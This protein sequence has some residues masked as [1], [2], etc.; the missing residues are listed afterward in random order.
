MVSLKQR[1]ELAALAQAD[2]HLKNL[3]LLLNG[4]RIPVANLK[5]SGVRE[6]LVVA[7]S[8]NN[9][10]QFKERAGA[11]GQRKIS[12]ESDWCR[13]DYLLF[14]LLLGNQKFGRPLNFLAALIDARRQNPN[15]MPQKINEVFAALERE[16]FSIDGEYGFLKIPYL[17]LTGKLRMGPSE[18][19]KAIQAMST[20]GLLD[21]MS[22]FL[23]LLTQKAYDLV[24]IERQ[25]LA[26]DTAAQLIEGIEAHAKDFSL[27]QWWRVITALPCRVI[28]GLIAAILSVGLIPILFGVGKGLVEKN[29]SE[30]PRVHP[31][32]IAIATYREPPPDLPPEV[33]ALEK[34]MAQPDVAGKKPLLVELE[35]APFSAPTSA[36][37]VEVS[38]PERAIKG[39]VAFTEAATDGTRPYTVVPLEHDTGRVRAILPEEPAGQKLCF[40]LVF[41][42]V[43]AP[44]TAE[45]V[46][47][48]VVVRPLQ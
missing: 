6:D 47:K 24:L 35:S 11:I 15:P 31:A 38:H 28:I 3:E 48:R 7:I 9:S 22:P 41:D 25:P 1:Q 4:E 44:E 36:F 34:V 42:A 23:K 5:S 40:I 21:Q 18:A 8:T 17:H 12:P 45:S 37:V 27:H 32:A 26:T 29:K 33:L 13:D 10:A 39:A 46:G 43:A 20:P 19:S 2:Q 14:L 16:E 30:A